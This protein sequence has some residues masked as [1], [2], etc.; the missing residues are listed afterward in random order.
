MAIGD[1]QS[2]A[3]CTDVHY[4]DTG[5][6]DAPAYGAVYVLPGP[7]PAVVDTGIGTHRERVRAALRSVGVSP[8]DLAAIVLTHV[9]LDHAG[10]AGFL[11]AAAPDATVY[12]HEAGA[13]HL[14]DPA[15]LVGGTK[16]A[17]GDMWAHYTEPRPVPEDRVVSLSDGDVVD[18]GSRTLT[19]HHAPGHAPHQ[20][21]FEEDRDGA[22]FVGDA[23]G[24]WVPSRETVAPTS[25]PPQFDLE[26]CL[27]DLETIR[28]LEPS[29]LLYPHFGPGPADVDAVLDEYAATLSAW[30]DEVAAA[31][32]AAETDEAAV[33]AL[34]ADAPFADVWGPE[35]ARAE[36][37]LN[38]RGALRALE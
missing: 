25:P 2:V 16:A 31:R 30:V 12:A 34:A 27:A 15:R 28:A 22:V 8:R 18:L 23:A 29:T 6:Y 26:R 20:V 13:P 32:A 5:M 17:V 3:A 11:A 24:I 14:V 21:V 10:G 38:A 7:R 19:A 33:D 1:V 36:V 37:R 4:V 9:H 35:K